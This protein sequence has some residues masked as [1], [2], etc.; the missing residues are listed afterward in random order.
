MTELI[1]MTV[2]SGIITV[3]RATGFNTMISRPLVVS[4][5]IGLI[6]GTVEICF[7][8]GL[9]FEFIG[10]VDVPVGTRISRD[11]SFGAYAFSIILSYHV[12]SGMSDFIL[13]LMLVLTFVYPVTLSTHLTRNL[14]KG[15]YLKE[16][17]KGASFNP[18]KLLFLGVL[19]SFG[20]GL[21]VYNL[22]FAVV[23]FLYKWFAVYLSGT[24]NFMPYMAF[25][26]IFLSGFLLRF[27]SGNSYLKYLLFLGGVVIGFVIL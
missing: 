7:L 26:T 8:S 1:L 27:L 19:F 22:A 9:M 16:L 12:I 14:N 2:F 20:Q 13:A 11:D 5:I 17:K 10:L 25:T 18:F 24:D 4:F 6:F 23:F 3:D 15:F 21:V